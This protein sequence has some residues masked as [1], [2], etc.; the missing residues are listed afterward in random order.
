MVVSGSEAVIHD[1]VGLGRQA[2]EEINSSKTHSLGMQS[3]IFSLTLDEFQNSHCKNGKNFGSMNMD[4]FLNNI[5]TA[6]ENQANHFIKH[7]QSSFLPR[8]VSL[9]LQSPLYRK[10]VEEVWAEIRGEQEEEEEEEEQ[11]DNTHRQPTI[12]EMTL[13]DFLVKAGVVREA[14]RPSSAQLN[15]VAPLQG[16]APAHVAQPYGLYLNNNNATA[17]EKH[18][19]GIDVMGVPSNYQTFPPPSGGVMGEM[20]NYPA[21]GGVCFGGR[22][23]NGGGAYGVTVSPASSGSS[24][25]ICGE[26]SGPMENRYVGAEIGGIRGRKRMIDGPVEVVVERR[27][28]RMIK[29]RE[30]AAR[31]RARKQAYTVELEAELNQLKE[32]NAHL[33]RILAETEEK[34]RQEMQDEMKEIKPSTKAQMAEEKLR[35]M[36]RSFSFPNGLC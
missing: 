18:N 20:S 36:R 32:E 1:K 34:K 3:S 24:D 23:G 8:Q 33:K 12:G 11:A 13:E 22:A 16:G 10:T 28:R 15:L 29:N 2:A 9:T 27:Q 14:C 31:S 6:E 26:N 19:F 21:I 5:W 17:L 35:M 4:E 30:S 25:G 7:Q